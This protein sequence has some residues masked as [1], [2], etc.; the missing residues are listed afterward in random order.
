MT[1]AV[2][3][4]RR[5]DNMLKSLTV[6]CLATLLLAGHFALAGFGVAG[7]SAM[8]LAVAGLTIGYGCGFWD[9]IRLDHGEK[10]ESK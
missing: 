10:K 7:W 1:A 2:S 6:G 3:R 8:V 4:F 5:P 9:G